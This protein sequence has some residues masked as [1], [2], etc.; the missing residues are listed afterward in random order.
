MGERTADGMK[1]EWEE[2]ED[3]ENN[4]RWSREIALEKN[5]TEVYSITLTAFW[6]QN[7]LYF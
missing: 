4:E 1:G 6:P 3:D 7:E 2:G 5:E